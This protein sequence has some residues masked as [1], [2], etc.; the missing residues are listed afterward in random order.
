MSIMDVDSALCR[1]AAEV[2]PA[3]VNQALTF[4]LYHSSSQMPLL[5]VSS[6]VQTAPSSSFY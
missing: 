6:L 5:P 4:V 1:L 3:E 2:P